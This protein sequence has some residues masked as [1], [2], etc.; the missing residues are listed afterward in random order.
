MKSSTVKTKKKES[1]LEYPINGFVIFVAAIAA[2]GGILFGFDTGVIS[3]AILF[4][5]NQFHL[6]ALMN[7]VVVSASL[8]GAIFGAAASGKLADLLGRKRLLMIAA[9][10][11]IIG[12]LS[13][14]YST[15]VPILIISRIVLG[16][17]IGI[18]S[19]TAPLYISEISPTRLR[20]A[21]VSLNQLAVTVGIFVSYFVDEYFSKTGNWSAMF[22]VGVIPAA[23]LF[24]GLIYLPYS[25]RW[26]CLKGEFNKALKVLKKIRHSSHVE[27]EFKEIKDSVGQEGDWHGLLRKW[28][29]PAIWIGVG[30]GFF[31]QF[32]G[33]NT[34]I[35][36]APTIFK[37]SGF[38]SDSIAIMATMGIGAVNVL[39]T[40]VAIPLID[41][42]G[43]KPLLYVGMTLMALCLFGL[44][45]SYAIDSSQLKW[46][47]FASLVFYVIGFAISL[48]PIMWLM[49]AEIFP[50]KVRGVAI[51]IMAS[52]QWLF[53]FIVSLTFLSLIK[54]FHETGTFA[55]YGVICVLGILFVY[56]KVPETKGVSLEKIE[57]NLRNRVPS[58]D[59][60]N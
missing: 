14:A 53:N 38:S 24:I 48:G 42:V 4:I 33:I 50:L 44:S 19:F 23:I 47:A 36:Y 16:I 1:L 56:L 5:K 49:F 9:I 54:Y 45:L 6:T 58:R 11:F 52:M 2:I 15:T 25:P 59:L 32:T 26:L 20:G 46:I 12:T 8:V 28:L 39:A 41:K 31:Q 21:L 18:S 29:R 7:G 34:V 43:R 3:G 57:E 51:S 17:A 35:Y 30:L 60:G 27:V 37:L 22:V 55:L 10:I 13:S 40:I